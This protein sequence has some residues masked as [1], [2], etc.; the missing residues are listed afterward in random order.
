M[1][2]LDW[3]A[4]DTR[5]VSTHWVNPSGLAADMWSGCVSVAMVGWSR[6]DSSCALR[7]NP[8]PDDSRLTQ[9]PFAS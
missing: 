3:Q 7:P 1:R 9:S 2:R 4:D 8:A 5:L 6:V